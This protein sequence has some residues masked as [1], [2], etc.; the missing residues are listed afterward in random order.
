MTLLDIV[1]QLHVLDKTQTI[2]AKEPWNESSEAVVAPEDEGGALVPPRLQTNGFR[3]FIEVHI[4][5]DFLHDWREST[6]STPSDREAC[7]RLIEY[8]VYDA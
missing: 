1:A 7:A 5:K 8:A 4:A 6:S 2:Y 3:Y